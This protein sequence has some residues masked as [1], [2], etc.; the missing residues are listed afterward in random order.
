M[1]LKVKRRRKNI[2]IVHLSR[3]RRREEEILEEE[4]RRAHF[5]RKGAQEQEDAPREGGVHL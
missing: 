5:E 2:F 4:K 1:R 3:V